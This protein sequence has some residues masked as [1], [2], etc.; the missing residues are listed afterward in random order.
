MAPRIPSTAMIGKKTN[1]GRVRMSSAVGPW[2]LGWT[3]IGDGLGEGEGEGE[4]VRT[5]DALGEGEGGPIR[6]KLAHGLLDAVAHRRWVPGLSPGKGVRPGLEKAPAPFGFTLA[7]TC[8][9][10]SQYSV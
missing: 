5:G 8:P 2:S 9:G 3:R 7:A 6:R 10:W 1:G 4:G